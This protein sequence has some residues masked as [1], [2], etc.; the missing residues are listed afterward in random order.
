MRLLAIGYPLPDP[1]IDNYNVFSA[2]S[3][4]DYDALLVDPASITRSVYQLVEEGTE[5]NAFDDRP[6]L[7]APTSANAVSGAEQVRRRAD[8]TRRLL[9]SG[10]A[11]LVLA[12]P[13]AVQGGLLGFEGCDRYSWLPA[14][15]GIAWGAPYIRPAEGKTVRVVAEDHPVSSVLRDFRTDISYRATFD[16]RQP[17]LRRHGRFLAN[18]GSGVPIAAEFQVLGGRVIF[19]PAFTDSVG[20]SRANLASALVQLCTR[21]DAHSQP[22]EPPYWSKSV[23]MP[24]L[25]QVEAELEEAESA[26]AE[27]TSRAAAVRERHDALAGHRR[28]LFEDGPPFAAAI[29]QTLRML[30]FSVR[31]GPGE[32]LAVSDEGRHAFVEVESSREQIVE[33]PYVRLQRRL[34][35]HLLTTSEQLQGIVVVNGKRDAAPD[36]RGE[37]YTDAL[38][39][40]CENYRYALVTAETLL[41]LT[42]RVLGGADESTLLG[43]RRRMLHGSGLLT[44]E[45]LLTE[46]ETSGANET[47]F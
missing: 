47:I 9:E 22:S 41:T 28:L 17:E 16:D 6:V 31:G 44:L 5:F 38:R 4:C 39:I 19:L 11:V 40:A 46:P 30:G 32:P 10:G 29:A 18:G 14:P 3:Y 23:P 26:A 1:S 35:E 36:Q 33:W 45:S 8:E 2:P 7:N 12:R 13:D 43:V 24:G 15:G 37:Q 34:E 25:E 42:R 21:L 20:A 27:A